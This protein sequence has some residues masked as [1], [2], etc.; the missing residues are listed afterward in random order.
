MFVPR[1]RRENRLHRPVSQPL[2]LEALEDRTLLSVTTTPVLDLNGLTVNTN[3]YS[4]TDILVRFQVPPGSSGG[5][6]LVAGTTLASP[7]PLVPGL[8]QVN[9]SPGM[10]VPQAL[11]A[12]RAEPGVLDAEPDYQ[13]RV[14]TV[15]N[16]PLFSQQWNLRNTG[17]TGGTPGADIHAQEAWNVTTGSPR[18]VVAVMDTG[19]DYNS[20]DLY[21]NIW[22]N[23]DEIPDQ[24]YTK[25]SASSGYDRLVYKWQIRTETPG[26]ITFRDL[27]NPANRGLVWDN[28]GDGRIDAGDLL[29]PISQGGW[30]NGSTRDGDSAHPDDLFGWNFV[31]DTNNP[32]DDNGHGTHV[33]GILGAAG[34]SGSG[35]AGVDWNVQIMPVKFI[36]SGGSGS[37][38]A[39]IQGL[40]YAVQHGAKIS[41]NSWEGAPQIQALH[42]A[43]SNAQAHGQIFVAAAGNGGSNNDQAGDYPASYSQSLNN[44][45]AVAATDNTDHLASFSNWG[46][47]SVELAAPGVAILSTLS[48]GGYGQMSG[49]SMA[50]PEVT[51]ALALVWGLHPSW[52]YTQVIDQVLSTVDHLPGLQ[53][54]VA[55]GG[56]LDLAAAVGWNLSTRLTPAVS[57]VRV[58]GLTASSMNSLWLTFNEPIDVSSFSSSAVRLT[59]FAG[60][61]IPVDV[62]VVNN[63]GD[64]QVVLLFSNQ[65]TAGTY[66]LSI[67]SSIRDLQGNPL[68][69]YQAIITLHGTQTYVN[70][71]STTINAHS[72]ATSTITVP[73]GLTVG[74]VQVQLNIRYPDDWDLDIHLISPQGTSIELVSRRGGI[75]ADFQNTVLDD[76]AGTALAY[77]HAPFAGTFRPDWDFRPL[78]GQDATGVWKLSID[79]VGG[80]SGTL[81]GWSLTLTPTK[82]GAP[83]IVKISA[84]SAASSTPT[85]T[86]A[87]APTTIAAISSPSHLDGRVASISVVPRSGP[88][89][90]STAPPLPNDQLFSS[91]SVL[92]RIR[93]GLLVGKRRP[94]DPPG[95]IS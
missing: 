51:G 34:D 26:V 4:A 53:G 66:R 82:K 52:S 76:A 7:L 56:R 46:P 83:S 43:I 92:A 45:V 54:R 78:N 57:S 62:R 17:Q 89:D 86:P 61:P 35:V 37:I 20:P 47:N 60:R 63:S 6:A 59:D 84:V 33:S 73:P 93:T 9:L 2:V 10:S 18:I 36:G 23:Q 79:D 81:L 1:T 12:Y 72:T 31:S 28:N 67:D 15:P 88:E 16:N 13:L 77:G 42:D 22:I 39:F 14:S 95:T 5:P 41:N 90:N 21:Q 74:H 87:P 38:S 69:P 40:N 11:A 30:M 64:R 80:H 29:R 3:Q 49:T 91:P 32:L 50:T 58:E 27:N 75:G 25:S 8:F 85:P 24:W 70:N 68:Q 48:G 55:T 19:I 71:S 94:N 65:S 44:V